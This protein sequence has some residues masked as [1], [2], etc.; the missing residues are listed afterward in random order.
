MNLLDFTATNMLLN[1]HVYKQEMSWYSW[2]NNMNILCFPSDLKRRKPNRGRL[3]L[4]KERERSLSLSKLVNEGVL[5]EFL[6]LGWRER[7]WSRG[8]ESSSH[9][10]H[11]KHI[12]PRLD[13]NP[14]MEISLYI[15]I[16]IY[17]TLYKYLYNVCININITFV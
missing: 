9:S 16:G 3:G 8:K 2:V 15:K 6:Q 12:K 4:G 14:W 17:I 7:L 1:I 11:G 10:V 5:Q 13:W